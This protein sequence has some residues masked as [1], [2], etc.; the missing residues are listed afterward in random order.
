MDFAPSDR[1]A[2]LLERVRDFIR[3]AR[4][5][6][7]E[8]EAIEALDDEVAPGRRRTRGSS[9]SCASARGPRGSGTCSS[10]TSASAP[11]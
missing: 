7:V 9:S 6:P 8:R 10:R 4:I 1:V 11:A 3:G 2:A 5:D